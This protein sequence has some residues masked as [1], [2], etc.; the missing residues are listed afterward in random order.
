MWESKCG[1]FTTG[2]GPHSSNCPTDSIAVTARTILFG[3]HPDFRGQGLKTALLLA[4][5]R[6]GRRLGFESTECSW[7]LEDNEPV[8]SVLEFVGAQPAKRYRLYQT[9]L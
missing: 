5:L 9:D 7:A 3:T 2:C 6:A 4:S 1:R 8:N